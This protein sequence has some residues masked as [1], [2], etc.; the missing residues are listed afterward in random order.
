MTIAQFSNGRRIFFY[1]VAFESDRWL[2]LWLW[3]DW[4]EMAIDAMKRSGRYAVN[5]TQWK[6]NGFWMA[7]GNL[8]KCMLKHTNMY[9]THSKVFGIWFVVLPGFQ[10]ML[11][12]VCFKYGLTLA[13]VWKLFAENVMSLVLNCVKQAKHTWIVS[14]KNSKFHSDSWIEFV[15]TELNCCVWKNLYENVQSC[16]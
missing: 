11:F 15:C 3:S 7:N 13:T 6:L 9:S 8:I 14:F 12:D 10:M 5:G 1:R 2:R 4:S 16:V